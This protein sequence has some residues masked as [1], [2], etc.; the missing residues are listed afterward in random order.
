MY[1]SNI[2]K[3]LYFLNCKFFLLDSRIGPQMIY[4]KKATQSNNQ[5]L[6]QNY[7]TFPN[8]YKKNIYKFPQPSNIEKNLYFLNC[9]FFLLDSRIGPQMIY[10]KKPTHRNNQKLLV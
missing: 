6:F 2:E 10:K 9:K 1:P 4:K 5:K 8:L 7:N 3:N